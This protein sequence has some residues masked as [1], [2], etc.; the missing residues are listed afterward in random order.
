MWGTCRW[1]PNFAWV[2]MEDLLKKTR[3]LGGYSEQNGECFLWIKVF[4]SLSYFSID[5][6]SEAGLGWPRERPNRND[7]VVK[8]QERLE[9]PDRRL[10]RERVHLESW[11]SI[12]LAASDSRQYQDMHSGRCWGGWHLRKTDLGTYIQ[13]PFGLCRNRIVIMIIAIII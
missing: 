12:V 8:A 1:V 6:L 11:R 3:S 4:S 13:L 2:L 10:E 9:T 7:G 5:S